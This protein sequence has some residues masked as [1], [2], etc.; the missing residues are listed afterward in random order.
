MEVNER[1][2]DAIVVGGGATGGWAAKLLTEQGHSVLLLEA[3]PQLDIQSELRNL[4]A[5]AT[6]SG[7]AD[8]FREAGESNE[9]CTSLRRQAVQSR[10]YAFNAR[11]RHLFVDDL[12]NPFVSCGAEPFTWIRARAI[13]GRTMLWNR[14]V[15]RM[16]DW[17]FKATSRDGL[18][19]DW[20]ISYADLQNDYTDVESFLGV[21]GMRENF[22]EVPDGCFVPTK[23]SNVAIEFQRSVETR[24]PERRVTA[25]RQVPFL[26][27]RRVGV[28]SSGKR[29]PSHCS[30]ILA[31]EQTGRLTLRCNAVVRRVV[32]NHSG[33]LATSVEYVDG[34]SLQTESA[35][36]RT[37][38]LCASTIETTRILL[39]STSRHHPDGIGNSNGMLGMYL[40]DHT[41][42]KA[43][44]MRRISSPAAGN[45]Y[46]PNFR[47][48]P[49]ERR[50]FSRGYGIQG[51]ILPLDRTSIRCNL[52]SFGETIPRADNRVMLSS[53]IKDKWGVPAAHIAFSY[54]DNEHEMASDQAQRLT[55]MLQAAGY[56]LV[57][58]AGLSAPGL[59]VHELGTARMGTN[60]SSSILNPHNQCWTVPN[61]F[62]TDGA[63]FAS[64]G[65]QNPTLTMLALTGR[66]C[67]YA[68]EGLRRGSW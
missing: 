40:C 26:R 25:L 18:G 22:A 61:L 36:G 38:F 23:L 59:S 46:I 32:T 29:E 17:Q 62:V 7:R 50:T 54:S 44:G 60:P 35:R 5:A 43:S 57:E 55:E 45:V 12:D 14:V 4:L 34:N 53:G 33:R 47:L 11:T 64:A 10:C 66:A 68:N 24:W 37:V 1:T 20:P 39:N 27:D 52:T 48:S 49:D 41:C 6:S 21:Q 31:A 8:S 19:V 30:A 56:D 42:V 63:A 65:F 9:P 13:G 15:L 28:L 67:R 51:L 2:F 58:S 16:S 3:G